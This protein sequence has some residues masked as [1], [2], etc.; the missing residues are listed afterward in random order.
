MADEEVPKQEEEETVAGEEE[1]QAST[2]PAVSEDDRKLFVGGLPQE[3]KDLDIKEYFGQYGE[4]DNINLK[5]DPHTGRSR[6]FAFIVFKDTE[7]LNAASA[8]EAHVIKGKKVTCK[9]AEA[10]QGK[11]Y[12]GKL[13]A[14]GV[15]VED[16]QTHFAQFG[17]V[18]EVVRPIDK[19]KNDE[20]KNFCFVTF[21]REETAKQMVKEGT[22]TINGHQID[23][24]TTPAAA[25]Q[26]IGQEGQRTLLR[27]SVVFLRALR[28]PPNLSFRKQ[29]K[30][31]DF[32]F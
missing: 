18:A 13:P 15:T 6:G 9:K 20:P 19:S 2:V 5:T 30:T 28:F 12:V 21:D 17:P 10:K 29:F 1:T 32:T 23:I 11:I 14:E 25:K 8:Q 31:K 24:Q 22:A 7:G 27:P 4:I 26:L 16:I 3:A